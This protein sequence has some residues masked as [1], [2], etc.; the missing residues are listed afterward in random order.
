MYIVEHKCPMSTLPCQLSTRY[1][2]VCPAEVRCCGEAGM[3]SVL[4]V[5]SFFVAIYMTVKLV[6]SPASEYGDGKICSIW[7]MSHGEA[8]AGGSERFIVG[9]SRH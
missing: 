4:P 3:N 6:L 8:L 1:T 2:S 5:S 9:V 7:Q